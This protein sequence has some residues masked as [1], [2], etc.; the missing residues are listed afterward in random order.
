MYVLCILVLSNISVYSMVACVQNSERERLVALVLL[1]QGNC[2]SGQPMARGH[3]LLEARPFFLCDSACLHILSMDSACLHI[4]SMDNN[5]GPGWD[6]GRTPPHGILF[7][8][9]SRSVVHD[10]RIIAV[11]DLHVYQVQSVS[12][13]NTDFLNSKWPKIHCL[14]G[15]VICP[16]LAGKSKFWFNN[17]FV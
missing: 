16:Y 5:R 2:D 17:F 15:T 12:T 7:V 14:H 13:T 11:L 4:L 10:H 8:Y 9:T 6:N 3:W 1:D